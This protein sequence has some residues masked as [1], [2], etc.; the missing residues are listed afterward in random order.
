MFIGYFQMTFLF[1]LYFLYALPKQA[2]LVALALVFSVADA[3]PFAPLGTR[4]LAYGSHHPY[5][6]RSVDAQAVTVQDE[7]FNDDSA[8]AYHIV[9]P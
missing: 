4:S 3:H 9:Q 6:K 5:G 8:S 7:Q 2:C 1:I